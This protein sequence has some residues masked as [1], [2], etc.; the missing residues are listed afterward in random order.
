MPILGD[1]L[2]KI[3]MNSS[4]I[5]SNEIISSLV[6]MLL[7][8]TKT[9]GSI[10]KLSWLINLAARIIRSGSSLKDSSAFPGVLINL[11]CKSATPL[12]R[13]IKVGSGVVSSSAIA[14]IVKSLL[15]KSPSIVLPN[16]TFGLREELS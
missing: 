4:R 8:A 13:S 3:L 11:F 15:A 1:G 6:A 14:L 2:I 7:I 9:D 12:N 5:R 16:S 10:S